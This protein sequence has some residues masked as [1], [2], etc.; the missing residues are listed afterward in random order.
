MEEART[1]TRLPDAGRL[2]LL[3]ILLLPLAFTAC[4][5]GGEADDAP[6]FD[7]PALI[8]FYTDN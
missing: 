1:P 8:M 5:A 3:T 7:G 6:Q 4:A 2:F